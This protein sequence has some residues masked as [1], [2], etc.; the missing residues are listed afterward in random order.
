MRRTLPPPPLPT[1]LSAGAEQAPGR[2]MPSRPPQFETKPVVAST[3]THS[4][5]TKLLEK[6]LLRLHS[7]CEVYSHVSLR[8][9]CGSALAAE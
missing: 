2:C 7:P 1:P 8:A 5:P 4:S 3:D 6:S 9:C